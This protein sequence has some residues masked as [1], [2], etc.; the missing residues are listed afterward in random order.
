M[1]NGGAVV[2]ADPNAIGGARTGEGSGKDSD[3]EAEATSAGRTDLT[4]IT[5]SGARS[6]GVSVAFEASASLE[7]A[8]AGDDNPPEG[9]TA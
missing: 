4:P 6:V 9:K 8:C 3:A 5:Y 7:G 1:I 2:A